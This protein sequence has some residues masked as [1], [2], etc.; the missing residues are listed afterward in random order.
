MAFGGRI[1]L[2]RG[3]DPGGHNIRHDLDGELKVLV[4]VTM[5]R[6]RSRSRRESPLHIIL[7][8]NF[9]LLPQQ[10]FTDFDSFW[11]KQHY[12]FVF[13]LPNCRQ[14]TSRCIRAKKVLMNLAGSDD[15]Q[16]KAVE[17]CTDGYCWIQR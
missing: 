11:C 12:D 15:D 13:P 6:V 2:Q 8:P 5:R 9:K 17:A 4:Q 14:N 1:L 3:V 16:A 10:I 7:V